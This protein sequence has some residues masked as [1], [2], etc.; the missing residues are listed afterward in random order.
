MRDGQNQVVQN[1]TFQLDT[2]LPETEIDYPLFVEDQ[3]L[4]AGNYQA[5][6]TLLYGNEQEI[7]QQA[8]FDISSDEIAQVF[9]SRAA[10]AAPAADA[11]ASQTAEASLSPMNIA[12]L[13]L[14][15]VLIGVL[16]I[17][18]VQQRRLR[19]TPA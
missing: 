17:V 15:I 9:G 12:V 2:F 8:N 7:S 5:E 6:L 1:L 11:P 10:L 16:V 14:L 18:A 19:R 3:A 13:I 4:A